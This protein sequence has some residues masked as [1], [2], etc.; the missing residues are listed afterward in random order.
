MIR[1][2]GPLKSGSTIAVTA[3]SSGVSSGCHKRLDIA[4]AHLR[5]QGFQLIEGD[6]LRSDYKHVSGPKEKRIAEFMRFWNDPKVDLIFPPWGGEIAHSLLPLIDFESLKKNP[7]W[8]QGYSD[9]ST[10]MMPITL[11]TDIATSHGCNLI[12]FVPSQIDDLTKGALNILRLS[13]GQSYRQNASQKWQKKWG[14]FQVEPDVAYNLTELTEWKVL[15]TDKVGPISFSGRL[16]GGCLDT[17]CFLVG[18]RFGD[19]PG[20]IRRHHGDGV[21]IYLENCKQN[22][23]SVHRHLFNMKMAGWFEGIRGIIL[24]R[25]GG[26][27][28]LEAEK[29][30][31][32][33]VLEDVLAELDLPVVYDCDIGHA[34]PQMTLVNGAMAKVHFEKGSGWVEQ[35]FV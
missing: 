8:V 35:R 18:T 12:D 11:L 16:I 4:I 26:P 6:C 5:S 7:T 1:Y 21:I 9:T 27:N 24:G 29:L 22:P 31:Y 14:D 2:P 30:Q 13:Q 28:P 20:F 17:I 33:E 10:Y 3:P 15:G 25:S 23:T 34:V 32:E 19:V